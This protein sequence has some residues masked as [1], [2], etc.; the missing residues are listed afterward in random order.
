MSTP[1]L[2]LWSGGK[3]C[4][5]AL[6][7]L[8]RDP[9]WQVVAALTTVTAEYQRVAMHGVRRDVLRAQA[10]ALQLPLIEAEMSPPADNDAYQYSLQ[11]AL[12]E[13]RRR[14]PTLRHCAFGDLYLQDVRRYREQ[15]LT[16]LGW[17]CEFPLWQQDTAEV[18]RRFVSDGHR[19]V[20]VCVDTTQLP[21]TFSGREYDA[22]CI[23]DLPHGVDPCG[24]NGEFHTLSYAG[25]QFSA[26]LRL[27]RGAALLREQRF[28]Y[29]DFELAD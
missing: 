20:I 6:A 5:M 26:P 29:C 24:E 15:L 7:T 12:G 28:Q 19:A 3:D 4:L 13:A 10:A 25:P 27:Q 9:R 2:M 8:R 18:A 11:Q 23:A 22:D 16:P 14:W 21:A 17:A 1:I